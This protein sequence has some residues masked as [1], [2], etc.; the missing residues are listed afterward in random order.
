MSLVPKK[1]SPEEEED[2]TIA[3]I[4]KSLIYNG[5]W[6]KDS[7]PDYAL[8]IYWMRQFIGL[9]VGVFSGVLPL[10]NIFGFLLF[11]FA[12]ITLPYFYYTNYSNINIDEF[13]PIEML[14]EGLGQ[15]FGVFLLSWVIVYS[16][17][18][19]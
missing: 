4:K 10:T 9:V 19:F 6:D 11:G 13:G 15:S 12:S 18:H 8:V 14:I 2:S 5:A 17:T 1:L 16:G 7:F 3:I